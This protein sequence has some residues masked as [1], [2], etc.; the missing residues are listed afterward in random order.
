MGI[1]YNYLAG[2]QSKVIAADYDRT[3]P[4]VHRLI[5]RFQRRLA[6]DT[7]LLSI[8]CGLLVDADDTLQGHIDLVK[9]VSTATPQEIE[10]LRRCV[11]ECPNSIEMNSFSARAYSL[12][13]EV[14]FL[15]DLHPLTSPPDTVF[16]FRDRYCEECPLDEQ[17]CSDPMVIN[18]MSFEEI[19]VPELRKNFA[20]HL[21]AVLI[22]SCAKWRVIKA[23]K[24]DKVY[25]FDDLSSFEDYFDLRHYI[26]DMW[27][28]SSLGYLEQHPL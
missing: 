23:T 4:T 25:E 10:T 12:K 19:L 3:E 22:R 26:M 13:A 14:E 20:R 16:Q 1:C 21:P 27:F 28:R 17:R 11:Y 2:V 24:E 15:G 9:W 6:E 7:Q 8:L 5:G 18:T